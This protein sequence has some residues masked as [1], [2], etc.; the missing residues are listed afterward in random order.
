MVGR[1]DEVHRFLDD[2]ELMV[3]RA[4]RPASGERWYLDGDEAQGLWLLQDRIE[5]AGL[6]RV[7]HDISF[8]EHQ[9]AVIRKLTVDVDT[10]LLVGEAIG[11][12]HR[13]RSRALLASYPS[14]WSAPQVVAGD[15]TRLA[16]C[17]RS[18]LLPDL[19][20]A[21]IELLVLGASA[22]PARTK[23]AA[24]AGAKP[25]EGDEV[26]SDYRPREVQLLRGCIARVIDRAAF[27]FERGKGLDAGAEELAS[28]RENATAAGGCLR[29]IKAV[30]EALDDGI[31]AQVGPILSDLR[32][33]A[34]VA[35]P[36]SAFSGRQR[37]TIDFGPAPLRRVRAT[38]TGPVSSM[39]A[40]TH[41]FHL[42]RDIEIP[43]PDMAP[44]LESSVVVTA[45]DGLEF[46]PSLLVRSSRRIATQRAEPAP[47]LGIVPK[48]RELLDIRKRELGDRLADIARWA[49]QLFDVDAV[50]ILQ[51]PSAAEVTAAAKRPVAY[52]RDLERKVEALQKQ[53]ADV[54]VGAPDADGRM[55]RYERALDELLVESRRLGF[56][57][58]FFPDTAPE[59]E[60]YAARLPAR[61][62]DHALEL[63]LR[64]HARLRPSQRTY[65][66]SLGALVA[67]M[68]LT[69]AVVSY[70]LRHT[71]ATEVNDVADRADSLV[72]LLVFVP[73]SLLGAV[74]S[75]TRT[76]LTRHLLR[77]WL[78][79]VGAFAFLVPV[80][81][82]VMIATMYQ[83]PVALLWA[84]GAAE[85]IGVLAAGRAEIVRRVH[86]GKVPKRWAT[87]RLARFPLFLPH[88]LE[89]M[90]QALRRGEQG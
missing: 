67:S 21:V 88:P 76:G 53:V 46:A 14:H 20:A 60:V 2:L 61:Q 6:V 52:L 41:T 78:N 55:R 66:W 59:A 35:L 75:T 54:G 58:T 56:R 49:K 3:M 45:P 74:L 8:A 85:V 5:G 1:S 34:M 84:T 86:K 15:G 70:L 68:L 47:K 38:G 29:W 63:D 18:E 42:T 36:L 30:R 83:V 26:T 37:V 64:F 13:Q 27:D 82:A 39:L 10:Q 57:A 31:G 9:T 33:V 89:I 72:T 32:H 22:A 81:L 40:R 4:N 23:P 73:A 62:E 51:A 25:A 11:A 28:E 80:A 12:D 77:Y 19:A 65:S 44:A 48:N 71:G 17:A 87:A 16:P 43:L 79:L 90:D 24:P 7:R 50:A 69:C